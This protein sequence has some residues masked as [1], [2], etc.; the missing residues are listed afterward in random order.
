[1]WHTYDRRSH[2]APA[3]R[4]RTDLARVLD[5]P[6]HAGFAV[7]VGCGGRH[8]AGDVGLGRSQLSERGAQE[9]STDGEGA[10]VV[11]GVG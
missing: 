10:H 1:M 7:L 6:Q 5:V 2:S 9:Q 8:A 4:D 3:I 11:R